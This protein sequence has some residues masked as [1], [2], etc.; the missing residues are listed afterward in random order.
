[1]KTIKG[2]LILKKDT[3]FKESIKVERDI[4]GNFDL[5]VIGNIDAWNINAEDINAWNIHAWD[6]NAWNINA[7]DINAWNIHA[8]D[9]NAGNINAEDIKARNIN[10]WDIICEKR[11]KKNKDN[12]TICRIFIQD[13]SKIKREEK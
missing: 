5:K 1:M 2:D 7:E 11:T 4:K 6:I 12:K 8:W 9:I 13:K 10:A 3:T